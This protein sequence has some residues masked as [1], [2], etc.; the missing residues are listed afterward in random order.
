MNTLQRTV[1]LA[2]TVATLSVVANATALAHHSTSAFDNSKVIKIEGTVTQFRWINP[3][4]S[5]KVDG[6]ADNGPDGL[7]TVEMTAANVLVNQGWKRS[8]LKPGDTVS[9]Y[10]NPL[11]NAI[12]LK[13]G[14]QGGLY[15]GVELA[16]GTILGRTDGEGSGS[17]Q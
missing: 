12:T 9:I 11:R 13:D 14:S 4:V 3:H 10:V 15:V 1:L 6:V 16:D 2:T 5:A 8:S 7:W 17:N